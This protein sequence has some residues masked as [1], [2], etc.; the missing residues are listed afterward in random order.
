MNNSKILFHNIIWFLRE[1]ECISLNETWEEQ[2]FNSII[3]GYIQGEFAVE[4]NEEMDSLIWKI[5]T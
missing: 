5:N 3:N 2:I 4:I 1:E